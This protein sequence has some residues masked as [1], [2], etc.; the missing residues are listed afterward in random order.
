MDTPTGTT[1]RVVAASHADFADSRSS[2][3][4]DPGRPGPAGFR[5]PRPSFTR[6][7]NSLPTL[8]NARRLGF[9]CTVSPV[10]G[11]A[12]LVLLVIADREAAEPA[13]LDPFAAPQRLDHALEDLPHQ[14]LGAPARKLQLLGDRIDEI[15][16]GH[17]QRSGL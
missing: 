6:S 15:G 3:R 9:T 12:A 2:R 13:D 14:Q 5:R 8:K 17:G 16:L 11:I 1:W 4:G 7:R 10:R